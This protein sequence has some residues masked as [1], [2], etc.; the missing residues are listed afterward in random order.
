MMLLGCVPVRSGQCPR[1]RGFAGRLAL[2]KPIGLQ[3]PDGIP[4]L[5]FSPRPQSAQLGPE[6][7]PHV[8]LECRTRRLLTVR[9]KSAVVSP[10]TQCH[11]ASTPKLPP[12]PPGAFRASGLVRHGSFRTG[13]SR[14]RQAGPRASGLALVVAHRA[15]PCYR[16]GINSRRSL[17]VRGR[18]RKMRRLRQGGAGEG[19]G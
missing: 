15:R 14:I 19:P 5:L 17:R 11:S 9:T 8:G 1:V 2:N 13:R 4:R 18:E 6:R 10:R 16:Q 3:S 12:C 7:L